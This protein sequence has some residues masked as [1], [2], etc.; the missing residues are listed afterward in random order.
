MHSS[1]RLLSLWLLLS[2]LAP[3]ASARTVTWAQSGGGNLQAAANWDTGEVPGPN[4]D[5]VIKLR[6]VAGSVSF[7]S[8][9]PAATLSAWDSVGGGGS[10]SDWSDPN[11]GNLLTLMEGW[12]VRSLSL[13]GGGASLLADARLRVA[14]QLTVA[15][16]ARLLVKGGSLDAAQVAVGQGGA[17]A[18][19]L[20][21][22]G[23]GSGGD[24][25]D[26]SGL[27][28]RV[29]SGGLLRMSSAGGSSHFSHCDIAVGS[30]VRA[31]RAL[32]AE[33]A[34]SCATAPCSGLPVSCVSFSCWLDRSLID[35]FALPLCFLTQP[36]PIHFAHTFS[37]RP[38][39]RY[40]LPQSLFSATATVP[41]P[42]LT[43][44]D[45]AGAIVAAA[46]TAWAMRAPKATSAAQADP[47]APG[48]TMTARSGSAVAAAAV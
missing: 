48:P 18:I 41:Q 29:Q 28:L 16:G 15:G 23:G 36:P 22:V 37:A 27:S 6:D 39:R 42:K 19:D 13:S 4:D 1:S 21:T 3:L 20:G 30:G 38:S 10:S 33:S 25:G 46:T 5:V 43:A 8:S 45:L 17:L 35:M 31:L 24:G 14:A 26:G 9:A 47:G 12:S 2:L 11:G 40:R 34:A 32:G 44:L 7:V